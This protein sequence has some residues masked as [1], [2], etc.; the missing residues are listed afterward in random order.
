LDS[1]KTQ[2]AGELRLSRWWTVGE[3]HKSHQV[4]QFTSPVL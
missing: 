4:F 2:E 1:L 3:T